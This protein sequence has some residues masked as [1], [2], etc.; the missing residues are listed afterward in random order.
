MGDEGE[1]QWQTQKR[2]NSAGHHKKLDIATS[3][4]GHKA[5][6]DDI[7]TFFF[8]DFPDS[9]GA[10]AMLKAFQYYGEVK[11]V[12]IPAKRDAGGRRSLLIYHDSIVLRAKGEQ[13]TTMAGRRIGESG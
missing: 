5:Y 13:A 4:S 6:S 3:N 9:F 11:E 2:R 1:N 8:T 10:Y 7:T 12:V